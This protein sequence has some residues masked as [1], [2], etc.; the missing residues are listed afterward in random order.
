MKHT[1]RI[2]TI[3]VAM[4]VM[5][6]GHVWADSPVPTG[7]IKV[8]SIVGGNVSFY[9]NVNCTGSAIACAVGG[10]EVYMK[11]T[12]SFGYTIKDILTKGSITVERSTT[13]GAAQAPRRTSIISEMITVCKE[14]E[15]AGI[16]SF[17]M[18]EDEKFGY[19]YNVSV[20]VNFPGKP[21]NTD[22]V[23]YIDADGTTKTLA[24]NTAYIIDGTESKMGTSNTDTWYVCTG[25][26]AYTSSITLGGD[27]NLILADGCQ[28][29]ATTI[30][31]SR[32]TFL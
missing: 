23:S 4:V 2:F 9:D 21:K 13:S 1:L 10:D 30:S 29:S 6:A 7:D 14:D 15:T 3:I 20:S 12:P 11:V 26:V 27:V 16:Y 22:D 25:D 18:P 8:K 19:I 28:M 31:G 17:T 32:T 24:A 5:S